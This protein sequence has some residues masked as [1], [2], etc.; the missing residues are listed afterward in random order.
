[1]RKGL[2]TVYKT[3][4]GTEYKRSYYIYNVYMWECHETYRHLI[5]FSVYSGRGVLRSTLSG[6]CLPDCLDGVTCLSC[7]L[8][9]KPVCSYKSWDKN[10]THTVVPPSKGIQVPD[11]TQ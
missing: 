3:V 9:H 8:A 5:W 2:E 10:L 6:P 4:Y 7:P 11:P 1:M